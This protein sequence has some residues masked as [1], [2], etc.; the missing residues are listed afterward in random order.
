MAVL[1]VRNLTMTFAERSLFTDISFDIENKDKVGLI[2]ANGIGKTTL[3]KIISG[4]LEATK[5]DVFTSKDITVGYMEQHSC[6][7]PDK[8]IYHELL[9]VFNNLIEMEKNLDIIASSIDK[10]QNEERRNE[11]ITEQIR[12]HEDFDRLGGLTYK[13]RT[14]STLLGLGFKESDFNMETGRLSGGQMSKLSLAKLLLCGANF[15]LLDEPTN[16]LDIQAVEW[17]ESFIKDFNGGVLIISHDRYFLDAVTNRTIELEHKK[18]TSYKGGYSLFMEKKNKINEDMERKYANDIKEIKRIEGIVEQQK[19]W[20]RERNFITAASKQK[21]ADRL[22]EELVVPDGEVEGIHFKFNPKRV[23][24]NDVLVTEN[25]SKSF[26]EKKLFSNVNIHIK[27][28]E[29]VF[30]LGANG[31]GK[32]TLFRILMNRL[33]ADSGKFDFGANVD[34]GYFDQVQANLDLSKTALDEIWD[35]FP[36]MTQT[37]VRNALGSFL[38]KGDDVFKVQSTL[39]GGERARIALLKLMLLGSNVL[40]L[41][42]PT[43]HLDT[44]SREAL[45]DT[46]KDYSGTMI[47]ISH[48]RYFINKLADRVLYLSQDGVENFLGNYDYYAEK[49]KGNKVNESAENK[50][51]S[52]EKKAKVNDYKLRKEMQSNMRKLQTGIKKCEQ[53]IEEL[54]AKIE[55]VQA[56]LEG[57]EVSSDY[58][59]LL[60]VTNTLEQLQKSQEEEYK[61][62][63]QL[64]EELEEMK[65]QEL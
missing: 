16:H 40:L 19:R 47:I 60:E 32:T 13:S 7:N 29:K 22:K 17:L 24:G 50:K 37:E 61:H 27:K 2:G 30:I 18:V 25:L 48:D 55:E 52:A 56:L 39:S 28:G 8:S 63:E 11:L 41:D 54:E 31:C 58:E 53:S 33:P 65:A 3:F 38:F 15:L 45:E 44:R 62:W 5:G 64:Q 10:E 59:K 46:L 12:M 6:K 23:T 21:Q 4:E 35:T 14:R 9:S 57:E 51:G 26:G 20:G 34:L 42:E 1:S 36:H 49:I 43:N